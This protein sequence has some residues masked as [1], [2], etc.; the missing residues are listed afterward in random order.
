MI[1]VSP[2]FNVS[3]NHDFKKRV[4]ILREFDKT[5]IP[6]HSFRLNNNEKC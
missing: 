3:L 1:N 5:N 6:I 4:Y 2:P